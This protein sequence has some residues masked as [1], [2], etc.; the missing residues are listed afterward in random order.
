MKGKIIVLLLWLCGLQAS[1]WASPID[2]RGRVLDDAGSPLAG[3]HVRV[4][5]QGRVAETDQDGYFRLE[6]NARGPLRVQVSYVGFQTETFVLEVGAKGREPVL[7][8]TPDVA[9][10]QQVVVTATRTPKTLKEVPVVTRLITAADI[11]KADAT[12]VQDL[13][14][15]ELPGLEFGYA[16]SQETSLT[17]NGLGGNS[18]LFLVDGERLAGETMNNVDYNRLSLD[19]VGRIEIVK[20]AASALYGANAVAGV[21]NV[22]TRENH[23]PWTARINSR[24]RDAG[25]EWRHGGTLSFNSGKWNAQTALQRTSVDPI[26]LADAFDTRSRIHQ[27]YGGET[28][29]VKQRLVFRASDRLRL[30]ARGGYFARESNRSNYDDHYRDYSG[31][32]KAVWALAREQSLEVSY[33][34]DRYDKFRFIGGERTHDHDYSNRQHALRALYTRQLGAHV[35]TLG[36]DYLHD[37]LTTYQFLNGGAHRQYSV[38]AF[39]QFDYNPTRWLNVVASL[40]HDYFSASRANAMTARLATMFKWHS[41]SLR[42]N[43]AGGFRAPTLKEMYMHFDMAGIQMIYGNPDLKPERSHNLNLALEHNGRIRH[44]ALSGQ[45]SLTLA[46]YYNRYDRRITTTD[47]PGDASR[48]KGAILATRMAW[49][50]RGSILACSIAQTSGWV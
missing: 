40:R 25:K 22:I 18:V 14:T 50:C 42:A 47:F 27:V 30:T 21:V 5:S 44:G 1:L 17:M 36:G 19:N 43:Y 7:R 8:L 15:E 45:Y 41:F 28:F 4:A 39:A 49:W 23:E 26:R 35:L 13:L 20:G 24:Y 10:L 29:D 9:A 34:Y 33:G 12:N 32:L 11:R 37:Y 3:A 6:V 31:G 48:E 16:M 38:D 46:G 2:V